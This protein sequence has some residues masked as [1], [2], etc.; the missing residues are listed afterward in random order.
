M[1]LS[2]QKRRYATDPK[3]RQ[4]MIDAVKRSQLKQK[5]EVLSHYSSPNPP[6]CANPYGQHREPYT[7][8]RALSIDHINGGGTKHREVI[9]S[10]FY[11]WL[12]KNNYP[13]DYQVLCMNC[14]FI[15]RKENNELQ[16]T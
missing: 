12:I 10:G 6:Q 11:H 3:F 8:I 15:K 16:H 1:L 7:D 14:Q 13:S 4:Y 9:G 5:I 2:T